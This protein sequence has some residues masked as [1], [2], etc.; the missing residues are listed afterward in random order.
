MEFIR[1]D[2][3]KMPLKLVSPLLNSDVTLKQDGA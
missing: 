2:L 3:W 1:Q